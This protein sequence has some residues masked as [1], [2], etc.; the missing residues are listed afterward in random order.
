MQDALVP[1][2]RNASGAVDVT[3]VRPRQEVAVAG[4]G[5]DRPVA[6]AIHALAF[7][8]DANM[9]HRSILTVARPDTAIESHG[10]ARGVSE[11]LRRRVRFGVVLAQHR[12]GAGVDLDDRAP[13]RGR[14]PQIREGGQ[15]AADL[16]LILVRRMRGAC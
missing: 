16:Q 13:E 6:V 1:R 5:L 9:D 10:G 2:R 11:G 14:D 12:A 4:R 15:L 3:R 8:E 7:L